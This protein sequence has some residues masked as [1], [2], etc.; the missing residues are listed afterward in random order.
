VNLIAA[1][2]AFVLA[3]TTLQH[4]TMLKAGTRIACVMETAIDSTTAQAG[5][6]FKLRVTDPSY[7][8]L[9]G[10]IIHG[11]ITHVYPPRGL[12]RA[13]IAFL[14]DNIVFPSKAR[15]PIRAFVVSRN[16]VQRTASGA[17]PP[18]L[19]GPVTMP[20]PVGPPN[21]STMVWSTTIGR[22]S[23]DAPAPTAQTGGFA[24]A[25]AQNKPIVVQAGTPA[26]LQ[27]ASDLQ[28]P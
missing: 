6:T 26:T 23:S 21:Q 5:D 24:Y 14:F 1:L 4:P 25:A 10:S 2:A 3:I 7:P 17:P 15:Q 16:V 18:S 28:T 20:N 22:R 13:E 27:L 8:L 12:N 9:D 19:Y 11:H